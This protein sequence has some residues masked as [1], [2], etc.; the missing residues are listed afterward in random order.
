MNE[1]KPNE[2]RGIMMIGEELC[3]A[4]A[5]EL[6]ACGRLYD[7]HNC[8]DLPKCSIATDIKQ[9][10]EQVRLLKAVLKQIAHCPTFCECTAK[11]TALEA[12]I[13]L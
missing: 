7:D 12:L 13:N 8:D 6:C 9:L 3:P 4:I 2:E 10:R 11:I 5:Y 1:V